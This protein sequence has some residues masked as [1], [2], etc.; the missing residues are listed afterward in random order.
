MEKGFTVDVDQE[1]IKC[2]C[3]RPGFQ[4]RC[5]L[6]VEHVLHLQ[7]AEVPSQHASRNAVGKP[8]AHGGAKTAGVKRSVTAQ[9]VVCSDGQ[10]TSNT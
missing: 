1:C 7:G 2:R 8:I 9:P 10:R 5:G 3:I 4:P 6:G